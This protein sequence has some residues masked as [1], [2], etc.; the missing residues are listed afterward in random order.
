MMEKLHHL[1]APSEMVKFFY[2][3]MTATDPQPESGWNFSIHYLE[4]EWVKYFYPLYDRNAPESGWR[5]S[6]HY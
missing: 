4:L 3:L 5:F 6:T 2:H 1:L